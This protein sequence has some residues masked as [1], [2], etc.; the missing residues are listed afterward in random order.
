MPIF[1]QTLS[2]LVRLHFDDKKDTARVNDVMRKL[3][4]KG[5]KILDVK[6]P[7]GVYNGSHAVYLITY[8]A[9]NHIE[10]EE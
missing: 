5:A 10:I 1:V 9:D 8:E 7:V 3:Q 6:V 4:E 2:S